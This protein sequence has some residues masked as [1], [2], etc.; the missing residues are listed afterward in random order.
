MELYARAADCISIGDKIDNAIRCNSAWS[1]L[2]IQ[3]CA[4]L[5]V[6]SYNFFYNGESAYQRNPLFL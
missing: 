2:P 6:I 4:N 1:L 3:V 5:L